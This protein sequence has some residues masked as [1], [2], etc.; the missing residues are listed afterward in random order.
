MTLCP[1]SSLYIFF[2]TSDLKILILWGA[3]LL[4][5]NYL[6]Q[7]TKSFINTK[8][9]HIIARKAIIIN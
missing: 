8:Y 5:K 6:K 9:E 4:N 1:T 2:L 3:F 7:A